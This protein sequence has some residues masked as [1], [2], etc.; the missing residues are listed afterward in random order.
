M[1]MNIDMN[2][3]EKRNFFVTVPFYTSKLEQGKEECNQIKRNKLD[4]K[5]RR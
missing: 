1:D 4:Y 2:V 5:S 3:A